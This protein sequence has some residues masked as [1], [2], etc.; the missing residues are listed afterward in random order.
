MTNG[1]PDYIGGLFNDRSLD[2]TACLLTIALF[3]S[4]T[5]HDEGIGGE[6]LKKGYVI[7]VWSLGD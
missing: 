2:I 5:P 3:K 1:E 4:K 7:P 6:M